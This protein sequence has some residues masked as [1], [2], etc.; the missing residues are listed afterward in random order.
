M[1]KHSFFTTFFS[2]IFLI[3][4]GFSSGFASRLI[5]KIEQPP[6]RAFDAAQRDYLATQPRNIKGK[7]KLPAGLKRRPAASGIQ[8]N[9]AGI[10]RFTDRSGVASF[11]F[12]S[13]DK[14]GKALTI[15][16]VVAPKVFPRVLSGATVDHFALWNEKKPAQV[17]A[18]FCSMTREKTGEGEWT[19]SVAEKTPP[20]DGKIGNTAVIIQAN[21]SSIF[22]PTGTIKVKQKQHCLLPSVFVLD[23]V[24]RDKMILESL[25]DGKISL[26]KSAQ[27]ASYNL[28][29][30]LREQIKK[31]DQSGKSVSI[32][33]L[34]ESQV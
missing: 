20:E 29:E 34:P 14:E 30:N 26:D 24:N 16:V 27:G 8:V 12:A 19:W 31:V 33:S 1:Q 6:Q 21:P 11:P 22:I 23:T 4:L 2:F 7:K 9:Y 32:S 5:V 13:S 17:N 25:G 15:F 28:L 10:R 3:M 18:C